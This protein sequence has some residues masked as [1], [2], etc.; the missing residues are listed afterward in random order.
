L[1]HSNSCRFYCTTCP[2]RVT[3]FES[4]KS[5]IISISQCK[6][7]PT[8]RQFASTC[9][10]LPDLVSFLIV[11]PVIRTL[12]KKRSADLTARKKTI[13]L[14]RQSIH[15]ATIDREH[16]EEDIMIPHQY[17]AVKRGRITRGRG[18]GR[19]EGGWSQRRYDGSRGPGAGSGPGAV[20][21]RRGPRR[22]RGGPAPAVGGLPDARVER[23]ASPG[24]APRR[25][26]VG[27]RARARAAA[28]EVVLHR[29][30]G[31]ARADGLGRWRWGAPDPRRER[32][33]G[34]TD[35]A[36]C[37]DGELLETEGG[38]EWGCWRRSRM[39]VWEARRGGSR[40]RDEPT[41]QLRNWAA[42][43]RSGPRT[44]PSSAW[45]GLTADALSLSRARC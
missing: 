35:H 28:A 25:R 5:S 37:L 20:V 17:R 15:H 45:V 32:A 41:K 7:Y 19:G 30:R 34:Q 10:Q 23:G 12:T 1:Y 2:R 3:Q 40:L 36:V 22:R 26:A 24:R 14:S 9:T 11:T 21:V 38:A 4:T 33:S 44:R 39:R 31:A 13:Q 6:C 27:A 29:R 43:A 8:C 16:S 42:R 18:R